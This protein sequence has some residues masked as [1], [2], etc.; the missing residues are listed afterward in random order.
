MNVVKSWIID[1]YNNKFLNTNSCLFITGNSGIG[2]TYGI[3]KIIEE[4]DLFSINIDI[5]NCSSSEQFNDIIIKS[6]TSSLVQILTNNNKKKIIIIDDF[7]VLLSIDT[8]INITLLKILTKNNNLKN[9]PIICISSIELIKKIGD[10]K[11]KCKIIEIKEPSDDDIYNIIISQYPNMN[12]NEI[13]NIIKTSSKNINQIFKKIENEN[14]VYYDI[15]T[16]S[17]INLLYSNNFNRNEFKKIIMIDPWLIIL[18]FHEN[19]FIELNNR[20]LIKKLKNEFYKNYLIKLCYFD[21]LILY[22]NDIAI[23][24]FIS[25]I[26]DIIIIKHKKKINNNI[27]NFTKILSYL[28]L[29]KKNIKLSYNSNFPLNQIGNYQSNIINKKLYQYF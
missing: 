29:Q 16:K 19:I 7:D 13:L 11:K 20:K 6:I 10:I 23:D 24:Y 1:S 28:S 26:Y 4:L 2:K 9:I 18:K 22:N 14:Q 25:I 12:S 27:N 3:N 21:Y 15:D 8:T 17:D 5:T